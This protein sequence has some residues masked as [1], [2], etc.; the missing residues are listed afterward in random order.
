MVRRPRPCRATSSR[1]RRL[2]GPSTDID[3]H[4]RP[5]FGSFDIGADEIPPPIANLSI[6]K[7]DGVTTVQPGGSLTYTIVV[8][9]LGPADVAAAPIT[10]TFPSSLT[11][12]TW[13]CTAVAGSSC[14][15]TGSGNA[16]TGTVTLLSGDSAT[17]TATVTLAAGAPPGSNLANT[18]TVAT[19][20]FTVDPDTSNNSATDTDVIVLPLPT[21]AVL[22]PLRDERRPP[23]G[24]TGSSRRALRV[25]GNQ[26]Q[27]Q[28][29][30][31]QA[32]WMRG[33]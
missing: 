2:A 1:R 4:P 8:T 10:D 28:S 9:N 16:R 13:T 25:N 3:G 31:E 15:A 33:R 32:F 22:D 18:A 6:T 20:G 5:A 23:S 19:P 14:A 26:A 7:T 12:N 17:F 30:T 11:V 29:N 24:P 27:A 21:L